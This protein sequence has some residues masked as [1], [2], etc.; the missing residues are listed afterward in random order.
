[1]GLLKRM[2]AVAMVLAAFFTVLVAFR[3]ACPPDI[4]PASVAS[5]NRLERALAEKEAAGLAAARRR[6]DPQRWERVYALAYA[7]QRD[8]DHRELARSDYEQSWSPLEADAEGRELYGLIQEARRLARTAEQKK[9]TE[10]LES[11]SR[12]PRHL[13]GDR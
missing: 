9:L 6:Y 10:V 11:R 5:R 4:Q 2:A 3:R 7:L 13:S 1:V 8:R 12:E